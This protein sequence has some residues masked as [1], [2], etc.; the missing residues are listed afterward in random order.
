M[1]TKDFNK[2]LANELTARKDLEKTN[3][4]DDDRTE[5][6][7]NIYGDMLTE[8]PATAQS[9]FG[10]H[11]VIT[12]R[13]KGMSPAELNSIR[14]TQHEQLLEKQVTANTAFFSGIL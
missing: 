3:E 5:I 13:W 4:E 14:H 2:A 1:A 6:E 12:D 7:N 8:N 11:R 10:S 9:A